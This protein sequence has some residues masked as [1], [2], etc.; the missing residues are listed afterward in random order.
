MR[1][2]KKFT[3]EIGNPIRV[4]VEETTDTGVN[5]E[6]KRR[7]KFDAIRIILEGPTSVSENTI[8]RQE[9]VELLTAL[10]QVLEGESSDITVSNMPT[11]Q[12]K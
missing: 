12:R 2:S 9:A 8:T 6:T 1:A 11:A 10:A 7:A 5:H 4:L 3:N